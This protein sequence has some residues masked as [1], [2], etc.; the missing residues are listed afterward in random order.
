MFWEDG[1]LPFRRGLHQEKAQAWCH[2]NLVGSQL[3]TCEMGALSRK[4]DGGRW[5]DSSF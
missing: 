1:N 3:A 4:E 2:I 5:S